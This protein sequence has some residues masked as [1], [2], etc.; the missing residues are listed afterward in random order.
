M[1]TSTQAQ[2]PITMT[3]TQGGWSSLPLRRA[4]SRTEDWKLTFSI[5]KAK[6]VGHG[7]SGSV[8]AIDQSKVI[9]VFS[10]DPDGQMDLKRER[11]IFERLQSREFSNLVVTFKGQWTSGLILERLESTLRQRLMRILPP[12][13][14]P[15]ALQWAQ[16]SSA[17]VEFVHSHDVIHG[18]LGCQNF[19]VDSDDHIKL[20]DFAGSRLG[21]LDAWISYEVRSQ[22]PSCSGQQPTVKTDIFALGSVFFEIYTSRPPFP[23][24]SNLSVRQKFLAGEFPLQEI[25]ELDVRRVIRSCWAGEYERVS[26]VCS[27]LESLQGS[28]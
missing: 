1:A 13:K 8:F 28:V 16:E 25:P 2:G 6:S 23:S 12:S 21:D 11:D 15:L 3:V 18:D 26:E 24:A 22:H 17:A 14:P 10:G 4:R 7:G 27:A 20:C 5:V 9:K 19:M